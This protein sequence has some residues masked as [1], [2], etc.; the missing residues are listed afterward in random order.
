MI[1][2]GLHCIQ[3]P[4]QLIGGVKRLVNEGWC[5]RALGEGIAGF[6]DIYGIQVSRERDTL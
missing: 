6:Q 3:F 5:F 4:Q 1:A 2:F